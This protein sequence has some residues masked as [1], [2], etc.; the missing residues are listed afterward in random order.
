MLLH[1]DWKNMANNKNLVI[2]MSCSLH[3]GNVVTVKDNMKPKKDTNFDCSCKYKIEFY[4]EGKELSGYYY[5]HELNRIESEWD[6]SDDKKQWD[7]WK[8][9]KI[10][11]K[12]MNKETI[13]KY[14]TEHKKIEPNSNKSIIDILKNLADD[15]ILM[16][17]PMSI[18]NI[19]NKR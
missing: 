8:E 14:I 4:R 19:I 13:D 1:H 7:E 15:I 12:F 9:Y 17:H 3:K 5:E 16:H 11:R 6:K 2:Y 18:L 10:I